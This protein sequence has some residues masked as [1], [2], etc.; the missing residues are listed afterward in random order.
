MDKKKKEGI[1]PEATEIT[2]EEVGRMTEEEFN[3]KFNILPV[4]SDDIFIDARYQQVP[5]KN[6]MN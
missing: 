1:H 3:K 6:K 5:D 4:G 2:L